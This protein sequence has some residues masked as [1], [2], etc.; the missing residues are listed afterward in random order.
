M[1]SKFLVRCFAAAIACF[2][3]LAA[4]AQE[5]PRE[6]PMIGAGVRTRPAYDGSSTQRAEAVPVVRY[7][8]HPL[9]LR[10]TRGVL[11]GGARTEIAPGLAFGAQVAYEQGR[12]KNES[13][14]LRSHNV[15]DLDPSASVGV[16]LELDRK[17]GPVPLDVLGRVRKNIGADQG[18]QAD[19][20]ITAGIFEKGPFAAGVFTQATWANTRST[21]AYYG[22]TP[23]LAPTTGLAPSAA[24]SGLLFTSMGFIWSFDLTRDW[25]AVGNLE[26]HHLHGDAARSPLTERTWT[27]QAVVGVA[28]RF[29]VR[30]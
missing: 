9:F 11:E 23:Q 3:P 30:P 10:S 18:V 25:V 29:S 16:H 6:Y 1:N 4:L 14:F 21:A 27:Y 22:I 24:G 17:V 5:S 20:R 26:T 13:A 8:G 15:P 19:F 28:Y 2:M 7:Y 12:N